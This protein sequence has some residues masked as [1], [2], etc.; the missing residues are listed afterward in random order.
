MNG[1]TI[2]EEVLKVYDTQMLCTYQIKLSEAPNGNEY[3]EDGISWENM[4]YNIQLLQLC[5]TYIRVEKS[6][7]TFKDSLYSGTKKTC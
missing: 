1:S 5:K 2:K 7:I 6:I 4:L 3:N